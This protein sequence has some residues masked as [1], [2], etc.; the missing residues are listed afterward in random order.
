MNSKI[1]Y[2]ISSICL[3][4][5]SII[6]KS[7][8]FPMV[9]TND[10]MPDFSLIAI[11]FFSINYGKNIG[12][13]MG[14]S[15]GLLLDSLSGVP[16]GLNSI[17]RLILG[18]FL[19]FFEGKIFLDRILLPCLMVFICTFVKY[20]LIYIV[21]FIFPIDMNLN[22]ISMKYFIELLMNL[23]FTPF[24]FLGFKLLGKKLYKDR[25]HL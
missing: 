10:Y 2:F 6:I 18:F 5:L 4:L 15:T 22:L 9:F 7:V 13:I 11:V 17:I 8:I 19:G 16:F 21:A 24:I 14:F 12:Q 20:I 1:V 23:V 25:G 3:V